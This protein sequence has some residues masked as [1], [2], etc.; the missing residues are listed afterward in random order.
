MNLMTSLVTTSK[1][2][3]CFTVRTDIYHVF[4]LLFHCCILLEMKLGIT[5]TTTAAT[6]TTTTTTIVFPESWTVF[7][8]RQRRNWGK[9][10]NDLNSDID[11]RMQ[12]FQIWLLWL[13]S[14]YF[15]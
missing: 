6:T 9:T 7:P 1:M 8:R 11:F 4:L 12:L 10:I 13:T 15:R 3:Q 2:Q 14:I 5:T